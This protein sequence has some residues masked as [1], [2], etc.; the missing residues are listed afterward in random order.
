MGAL[1]DRFRAAGIVLTALPGG[2]LQAAGPLTDALRATIRARKP[3]LLAELA[4]N[5]SATTV[6]AAELR[7]LVPE[8]CG[9]IGEA[10]ADGALAV[11]L[12]DPDAALLRYRALAADMPS[13]APY[14][15]AD[16]HMRACRDCANLSPSGRCLAAARGE[17]FGVGTAVSRR[18]EPATPDA[19]QRCGPFL[20][21]PGDPDQRTGRERWPIFYERRERE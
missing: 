3:D 15:Y 21:L 20:P 12:A 4:A 14:R 1:I 8:V 17:S 13:P 18:Y 16:P 11:A 9:A 19:P 2:R 5:D 6:Q 10:D 7:R